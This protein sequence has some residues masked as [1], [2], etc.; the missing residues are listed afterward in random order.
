MIKV[1]RQIVLFVVIIVLLLQ[2]HCGG[3]IATS[4]IDLL[5]EKYVNPVC[6][7]TPS[8]INI[9]IAIQPAFLEN[10]INTKIAQLLYRNDSLK[11]IPGISTARLEVYRADNVQIGLLGDE[12][13]YKIPLKLVIDIGVGVSA[14]GIS[15]QQ[16]QEI[17]GSIALRM[18][19]VIS[20]TPDW[21]LGTQTFVDG[22]TWLSSPS[23]KIASLNIP[24]GPV[25]D[26]VLAVMKGQIGKIVDN[27]VKSNLDL[28]K[29]VTPYWTMIQKPILLN[30]SFNLWLKLVPESLSMTQLKGYNGYLAS[31]IGIKTVA[32][33]F[34]GKPP[35]G[36]TCVIIPG[37]N[38]TPEIQGGFIL[39]MYS[40]LPFA[41]AQNITRQLLCK[42][43]F[44]VGGKTIRIDSLWLKG[45]SG[46]IKIE[47]LVSG[48]YKG[49]LTLFGKPDFDTSTCVF[50]VKNVLFDMSMHSVLLSS[51]NWMLNGF[52]QKKISDALVIPLNNELQK[53][54]NIINTSLAGFKPIDNISF[55]GSIDSLRVRGLLLADS[56]I[57]IAAEAQGKIGVKFETQLNIF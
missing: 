16:R 22:Y 2:I 18:R 49:K 44:K 20:V 13:H 7:A 29:I 45:D 53:T 52:I 39:N 8:I 28:S 31:S 33:T 32:Q 35:L 50:S 5:P 4:A 17:S 11:I 30:D 56:T 23:V 26:L 43:E 40:E 37:L 27:A 42:K 46:L 15:L 55:V 12:L 47:A 24:L 51:A 54:R 3:K 34:C 9:P 21:R 57:R 25:A 48:S 1:S 14:M 38:I 41:E 6:L 10:I 36:D 19:S